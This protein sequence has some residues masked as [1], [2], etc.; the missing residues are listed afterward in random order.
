MERLIKFREIDIIKVATD[1]THVM[2][3][4]VLF[5]YILIVVKIVVKA[6]KTAVVEAE[7]ADK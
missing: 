6:A 3:Y 7:R 1:V 5:S 4:P 2:L